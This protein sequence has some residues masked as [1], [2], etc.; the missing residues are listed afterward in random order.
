M[1]SVDVGH[2]RNL[3][4]TPDPHQKP[5]VKK[6]RQCGLIEAQSWAR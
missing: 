6:G 4:A 2:V 1:T 3:F 5:V